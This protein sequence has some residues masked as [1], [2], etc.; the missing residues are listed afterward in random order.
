M[1][2]FKIDVWYRTVSYGEIEKDFDTHNI[3]ANNEI[4]ALGLARSLYVSKSKIPFQINII[5]N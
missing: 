3:I 2:N 1:K 5:K 4:E